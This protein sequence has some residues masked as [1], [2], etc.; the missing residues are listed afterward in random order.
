MP[1][2]FSAESCRDAPVLTYIPSTY[3]LIQHPTQA[4]LP[5]CKKTVKIPSPTPISI[6][7]SHFHN[8]IRTINTLYPLELRFISSTRNIIYFSS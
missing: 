8:I 1:R 3:C 6:L 2:R 4:T 7:I 5:A